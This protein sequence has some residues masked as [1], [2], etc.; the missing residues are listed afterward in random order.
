VTPDRPL[1]AHF[2]LAALTRTD[3]AELQEENRNVSDADIK[4]LG[5]VANLLEKCREVLGGDLEVH[6]ARRS[7]RL[8]RL[9]GG[10]ERSQHLKCE[11]AD[12]SP[13]GTATEDACVDAWQKLAQAARDKKL[14]FGQLIVENQASRYGGRAFWVHI[15]LGAPYRTADKCGEVLSMKDGEYQLIARIP[16][17]P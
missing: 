6:S 5:E 8:N 15:S 4:K 17:L 14:A 13:Q 7:P 9:V 3:H 1:S 12:F 16:S 10:S 2:T 11:A